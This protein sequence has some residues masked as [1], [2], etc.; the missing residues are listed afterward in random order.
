MAM[1]GRLLPAMLLRKEALSK[2]RFDASGVPQTPNSPHFSFFS[3]SPIGSK[4][5]R[6]TF[7]V[8]RSVSKDRF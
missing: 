5:G 6:D 4:Q 8:T 7:T 3:Y 1:P 2:Q